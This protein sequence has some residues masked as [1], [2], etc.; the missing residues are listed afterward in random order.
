MLDENEF[1]VFVQYMSENQK[2]RH[3]AGIKTSDNGKQAFEIYNT[4]SPAVNGVSK[5]DV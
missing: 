4:F 2:A 1:G 3:G 5:Q